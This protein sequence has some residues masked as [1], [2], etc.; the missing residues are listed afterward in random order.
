VPYI[1]Q[2]IRDQIDRAIE[3]L[4]IAIIQIRVDGKHIIPDA[5]IFNYTVSTLLHRMH[6]PVN[7]SNINEVM[8]ILECVKQEYYRRVA[9]PYEDTKITENGDVY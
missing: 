7:Y 9:A 3:D 6:G 2:E 5:G 8:G 4:A 1:K